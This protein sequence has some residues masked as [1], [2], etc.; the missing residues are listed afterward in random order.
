MEG[1]NR[2]ETNISELNDK[3]VSSTFKEAGL[4]NEKTFYRCVRVKLRV[5]SFPYRTNV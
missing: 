1:G 2:G 4:P 3:D 5:I